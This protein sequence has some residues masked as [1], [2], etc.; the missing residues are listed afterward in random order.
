MRG[1]AH[2]VARVSENQYPNEAR[3]EESIVSA[4]DPRG[5]STL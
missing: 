2:R 4:V 3:T 5:A 1:R